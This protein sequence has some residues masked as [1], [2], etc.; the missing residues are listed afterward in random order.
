MAVPTREELVYLLVDQLQARVAELE[1]KLASPRLVVVDLQPRAIL[2]LPVSEPGCLLALARLRAALP[3]PAATSIVLWLPPNRVAPA[4]RL[5]AAVGAELASWD[6]E[7][8]VVLVDE[9]FAEGTAA[10]LLAEVD[11]VA[12]PPADLAAVVAAGRRPPA[13]LA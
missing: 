4:P 3:D 11:E 1:A 12:W 9:P 10:R 13:V 8:D 7:P 5:L 2:L 6:V